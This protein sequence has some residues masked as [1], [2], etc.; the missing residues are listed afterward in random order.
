MREWPRRRSSAS[1]DSFVIERVHHLALLD[2]DLIERH[3]TA[4]LQAPGE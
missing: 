1:A 2:P 4:L 3:V